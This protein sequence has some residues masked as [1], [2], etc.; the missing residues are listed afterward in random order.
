MFQDSCA[1]NGYVNSI[2][3]IAITGLNEDGSNPTYSEDCAGIMAAAYSRDTARGLG[4]I[5]SHSIMIYVSDSLISPKNEGP[6]KWFCFRAV[7]NTIHRIK[8]SP[9]S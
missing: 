5:V 8:P 7:K 6:V 9:H 4:K 2:Y 1:Y 3:T